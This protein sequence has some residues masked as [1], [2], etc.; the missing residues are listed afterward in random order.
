MIK[1]IRTHKFGLDCNT[2]E[3]YISLV[4]M[5]HNVQVLVVGSWG[6]V[7]CGVVGRGPSLIAAWQAAEE[8]HYQTGVIIKIMS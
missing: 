7:V 6:V 8:P 2:L 3:E 1:D 5:G 4:S